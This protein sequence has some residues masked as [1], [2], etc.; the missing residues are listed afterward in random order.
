MPEIETKTEMIKV[1]VT[2]AEKV[3]IQVEAEKQG[4]TVSDLL[5]STATN[6]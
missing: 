5:R 6:K 1:R 4:V 3:S 2:P